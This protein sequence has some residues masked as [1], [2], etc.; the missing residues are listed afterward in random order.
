MNDNQS[1]SRRASTEAFEQSLNALE[2]LLQPV[3]EDEELPIPS[4]P[5][6]KPNDFDAIE[7]DINALLSEDSNVD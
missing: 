5:D 6:S 3:D 7:V 1:E 2:D 4:Q